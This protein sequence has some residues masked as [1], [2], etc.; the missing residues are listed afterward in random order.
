M[1]FPESHNLNSN[2]SLSIT[3]ALMIPHRLSTNDRGKKPTK[4]RYFTWTQRDPGKLCHVDW[5]P[6]VHFIFFISQLLVHPK[7]PFKVNV[8]NS[9]IS[10]FNLIIV[11]RSLTLVIHELLLNRVI[12]VR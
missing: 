8:T 10:V 9:N 4:P 2:N 3:D 5:D 11:S 1:G 7:N 12:N 6:M